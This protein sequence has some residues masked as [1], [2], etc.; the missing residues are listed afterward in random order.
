[1]VRK[2]GTSS[3]MLPGGKIESDEEPLATAVREI[4]EETGYRVR[5]GK[6]VGNVSYPVAGRT[7]L[8]WYWTAEVL[9]GVELAFRQ[10]PVVVGGT[11]NHADFRVVDIAAP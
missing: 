4:W 7:K 3:F 1:M 5:L 11:V 2:K 6:L 8:V 10:R 9:A